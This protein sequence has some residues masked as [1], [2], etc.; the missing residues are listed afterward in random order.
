MFWMKMGEL[1]MVCVDP[2]EAAG[3]GIT[4]GMVITKWEQPVKGSCGRKF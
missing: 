1:V 3:A 4:D 2:T